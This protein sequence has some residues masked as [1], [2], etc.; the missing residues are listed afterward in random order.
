MGAV[1]AW[2]TACSTAS[3]ANL[4][5]LRPHPPH[6]HLSTA[7]WISARLRRS[8]GLPLWYIRRCRRAEGLPIAVPDDALGIDKRCPKNSGQASPSRS[9]AAPAQRTQ[10]ATLR[11]GGSMPRKIQQR[12]PIH[13][14]Q[15]SRSSRPPDIPGA[16]RMSGLTPLRRRADPYRQAVRRACRR[17]LV[18]TTMVFHQAGLAQRPA[19]GQTAVEEGGGPAAAATTS[20]IAHPASGACR[21]PGLPSSRSVGLRRNSSPGSVESASAAPVVVRRFGGGDKGRTA[22]RRGCW[23]P[24]G[25]KSRCPDRR[26]G[27]CARLHRRTRISR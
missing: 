14:A 12:L 9:L 25:A 16:R 26:R 7:R 2:H 3:V 23:L 11:R 6:H 4:L 8:W 17:S 10:R 1:A 18:K 27:G 24:A 19:G 5:H 13:C 21:I 22:A 15:H 20:G